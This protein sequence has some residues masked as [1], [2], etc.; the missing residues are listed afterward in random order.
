MEGNNLKL[1][2]RNLPIVYIFEI[3][4][5]PLYPLD[6][7]KKN[8]SVKKDQVS[9]H[10][11]IS[12]FNISMYFLTFCKF[13]SFFSLYRFKNRSEFPN[14]V[15]CTNEKMNKLTYQKTEIFH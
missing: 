13:A 5:V 15:P 10:C 9:V 3:F 2:Q 7:R 4:I 14:L 1:N 11:Y 12:C 6:D 8:L